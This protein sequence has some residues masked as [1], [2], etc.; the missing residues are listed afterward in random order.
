M[1]RHGQREEAEFV[2]STQRLARRALACRWS[3]PLQRLGPAG[4][5]DGMTSPSDEILFDRRG[6]AGL[7]TLNRPKALNAVTHAMVN[8]LAATLVAWEHDPRVTRVVVTAAGERA[9]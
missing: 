9:F 5:C 6:A 3:L 7:V 4:S 2:H 1:R 8:A